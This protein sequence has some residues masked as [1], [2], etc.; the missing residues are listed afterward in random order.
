MH[1]G[2][3]IR[4]VVALVCAALAVMATCSVCVAAQATYVT[5]FDA[6]ISVSGTGEKKSFDGSGQAT[7]RSEWT[8]AFSTDMVVEVYKNKL[9]MYIEDPFDTLKRIN[10]TTTTLFEIASGSNIRTPELGASRF[11]VT[12]DS[13]VRTWEKSIDGK[14]LILISTYEASGIL[15]NTGVGLHISPIPPAT[16]V[17]KGPMVSLATEYRLVVSAGNLQAYLDPNAPKAKVKYYDQYSKTW[18]DEPQKYGISPPT[19]RALSE[20]AIRPDLSQGVYLKPAVFPSARQLEDY[21]KNPKGAMTFTLTGSATTD[22]DYERSSESVSVT[23]TL[24]PRQRRLEAVIMPPTDYEGWLPRGSSDESTPG[25]NV[26][27]TIM[28]QVEDDPCTLVNEKIN[29]SY[30]LVDTS[31]E[32][33][34]CTNSPGIDLAAALAGNLSDPEY[35]MKI[36]ARRNPHLDVSEDGQKAVTK[37]D[38]GD[39]KYPSV[40]WICVDVYDYG[41]RASLKVTATTEDG[42]EIP[43]HVDG[44]PEQNQLCIPLDD[45]DN[46]VADAWEKQMGVF[47]K[48]LAAASDESPMPGGQRGTGDGM[49]LYDKYRGVICAP[50]SNS[51]SI[52][53]ERLDPNYKHLFV[54]DANA[55]MRYIATD[56]HPQAAALAFEALSGLR[57]RTVSG[58]LWTGP[59]SVSDGRRIVNFNSGDETRAVEQTALHITTTS[60]ETLIPP[61]WLKWWEAQT[62]KPLTVGPFDTWIVGDGMAFPDAGGPGMGPPMQTYQINISL[63]LIDYNLKQSAAAHVRRQDWAGQEDDRIERDFSRWVDET[64]HTDED[65]HPQ[66]GQSTAFLDAYEARKAQRDAERK[67]LEERIMQAVDDYIVAH[68]DEWE[69]RRSIQVALVVAHELGHGVGISHHSRGPGDPMCIMNVFQCDYST[70][71]YDVLDARQLDKVPNKICATCVKQIVVS[72]L[73]G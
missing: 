6:H 24:T 67:A 43:V 52:V 28:A 16:P 64:P 31:R 17:G 56:P 57:I 7:S 36:S 65:M 30:E 72:D 66:P 3:R 51:D 54:C 44:K 14:G 46:N 1:T 71:P 22:N 50:L 15:D 61:G 23:L 20:T 32:R 35:D 33:G 49:S 5:E 21:F 11:P 18:M 8:E 70:D 55:I 10:Y 48:N 62:G 40:G 25:N 53:H 26:I 2:S 39:S 34:V 63:G 19:F 69:R 12:V 47:G 60:D 9:D 58:T 68:P 41:A 42:K 59:G 38:P 37:K 27:V 29:Y 45:N 73:K 4:P 13:S